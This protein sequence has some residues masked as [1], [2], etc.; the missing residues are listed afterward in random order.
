MG[1]AVGE[2][3]EW[4]VVGT[5]EK[6]TEVGTPWPCCSGSGIKEVPLKGRFLKEQLR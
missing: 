6:E 3:P 4:T 5:G 2:E 1:K